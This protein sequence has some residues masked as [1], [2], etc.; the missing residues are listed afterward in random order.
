MCLYTCTKHASAAHSTSPDPFARWF[1]LTP[2]NSSHPRHKQVYS[3]FWSTILLYYCGWSTPLL[4]HCG[5]RVRDEGES[6]ARSR[7]PG[8]CLSL[9]YARFGSAGRSM[10]TGEKVLVSRAAFM[11][12]RVVLDRL[13]DGAQGGMSA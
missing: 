2:Q 7:W 4:Y 3:L 1:A 11:C 12:A 6:S 5:R 8:P 10:D 13:A 9:S